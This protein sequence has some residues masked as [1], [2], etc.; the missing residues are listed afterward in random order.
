MQ[1]TLLQSLRIL[2]AFNEVE[3][4]AEQTQ[5][6]LGSGIF[7]DLLEAG[8]LGILKTEHRNEIRKLLGLPDWE[9]W[10]S[11]TI[12]GKKKEQMIQD[13]RE[14]ATPVEDSVMSVLNHFFFKTEDKL[15]EICLVRVKARD[16]CDSGR[17]GNLPYIYARAKERGLEEC[18][19]E[20]GIRIYL[21][22]SDHFRHSHAPLLTAMSGI[23]NYLFQ[24]ERSNSGGC[25]LSVV[26]IGQ[27]ECVDPKTEFIFALDN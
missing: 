27:T 21:E 6:V 11:I 16:L 18:P 14:T 8:R 5:Q 12:G 24:I 17:R 26:K 3:L 1:A 2:G 23:A 15:R 10:Q 9:V 20:V 22:S 25:K 13:V 4:S 19:C 7:T